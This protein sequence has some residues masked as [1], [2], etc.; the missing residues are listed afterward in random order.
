MLPPAG[1]ANACNPGRSGGSGVF[2]SG[3]YNTA[4]TAPVDVTS[5]ILTYSPYVAPGAAPTTAWDMLAGPGA[6][7]WAQ[8]GWRQDAGG[9]RTTFSQVWD[10]YHPSPVTWY[11]SGTSIGTYHTYLVHYNSATY[12]FEFYL[13]GTQWPYAGYSPGANFYPSNTQAA[14]EVKDFNSQMPGNI[15]NLEVFSGTQLHDA[16]G[17]HNFFPYATSVTTLTDYGN[18]N[19][20]TTTGYVWDK[21]CP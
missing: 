20:G 19:G 8:M 18:L 13:D 21:K 16:N 14:G 2:F 4:Y 6:H 3:W 15:S 7:D 1:R 10:S 17:W 11:G 9:Y 5:T 12:G